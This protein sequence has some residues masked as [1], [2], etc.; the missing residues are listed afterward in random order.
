[1]FS[2][3]GDRSLLRDAA[4]EVQAA[5]LQDCRA[6][7]PA[8]LRQP[9]VRH[10]GQNLHADSTWSPQGESGYLMPLLFPA[11]VTLERGSV[12]FRLS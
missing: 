6:A 11:G 12:K 8:H 4:G 7:R 9:A 5:R 10:A 2:A 1:M 3:G